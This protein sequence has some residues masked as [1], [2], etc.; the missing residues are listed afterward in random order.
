LADH[1][2]V[3]TIFG[4]SIP[5]FM[6]SLWLYGRVEHLPNYGAPL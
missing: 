4:G 1:L 5:F 6:T 3:K 2:P